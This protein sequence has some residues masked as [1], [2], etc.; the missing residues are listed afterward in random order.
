MLFGSVGLTL[1]YCQ[2][3][4]LKEICPSQSKQATIIRLT[5]SNQIIMDWRVNR[6]LVR[7]GRRRGGDA[8][9][10][11]SRPR[12]ASV[13]LEDEGRPGGSTSW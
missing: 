7:I 10:R 13:F 2:S 9:A 6:R 5:G 4:G 12:L 11:Q 8:H 1:R 3:S